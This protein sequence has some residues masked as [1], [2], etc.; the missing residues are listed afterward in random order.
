LPRRAYETIKPNRHNYTG[1]EMAASATTF[2]DLTNYLN[3]LA[4]KKAAANVSK[5]AS[6]DLQTTTPSEGVR[7]NANDKAL[8]DYPNHFSNAPK[9]DEKMKPPGVGDTLTVHTADDG[10]EHVEVIRYGSATKEASAEDRIREQRSTIEALDKLIAGFK[11]EA[12][13]Q[14]TPEA[15]PVKEASAEDDKLASALNLTK[16]QADKAAAVRVGEWVKVSEALADDFVMYAAAYHDTHKMLVKMAA[17]GSLEQALMAAAGPAAGA[18]AGLPPELAGGMPPEMAAAAAPP[19][20]P[21]AGGAMSD[22][23]I[24]DQALAQLMAETGMSPD[25]LAEAL[26]AHLASIQGGGGEGGESAPAPAPE[27]KAAEP[28][29]DEGVPPKKEAKNKAAS[30][31]DMARKV[32]EAVTIVRRIGDYSRSGVK[33]PKVK[34]T[35]QAQLQKQALKEY[36]ADL[37]RLV[38]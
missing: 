1:F 21:D 10:V 34:E 20:G 5:A 6:G 19:A 3:S 23:Q 31:P 18:P 33:A 13:P 16:D 22:D 38:S 26:E 30:T 11:K 15:V 17:D 36:F 8:K 12:K 7:D 37:R 4:Q 29:G 24:L 25:Q 27:G 14:A 2:A 9:S 28:D 35:K 32:A